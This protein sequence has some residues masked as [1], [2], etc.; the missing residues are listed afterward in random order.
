M[1]VHTWWKKIDRYVFERQ[2]TNY[3][4]KINNTNKMVEDYNDHEPLIINDK[5]YLSQHLYES[6]GVGLFM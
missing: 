2:N 6:C 3:M 1:V 4:Q 5:E